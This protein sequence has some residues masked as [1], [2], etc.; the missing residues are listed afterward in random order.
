MSTELAIQDL[1][2]VAKR[3]AASRLFGVDENQAFA[4]MLIAQ[5]RGIPAIEAMQRFHVIQG[6]PSMKSESMLAEWQRAG[7]TCRWLET[8][9]TRAEAEFAH[10][11]FA[12][13]PR[14]ISWTIEDAERAGILAAN[15]SWKKYP[16][17]MLRARV[18]SSAIRMLAPGLT[19]G[20]YTPEEALEMGPPKVVLDATPRQAIQGVTSELEQP[21]EPETASVTLPA[22]QS[23]ATTLDDWLDEFI[24]N[25]N[26]KW[27]AALEGSGEWVSGQG[28][29][30]DDMGSFV[31]MLIDGAT[32][33]GTKL[34]VMFDTE[35]QELNEL[36]SDIARELWRKARPPRAKKPKTATSR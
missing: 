7:G 11:T 19:L 27:L 31:K 22:T 36:A 3:A 21:S 29:L 1:E 33:A 9:D 24:N 14:Q 28:L 15:P 26:A 2:I 5:S 8:S 30:I 10:P 17:A 4:L 32:K 34:D 13:E 20:F 25:V 12:P 18:V 6:R 16:S 35:R 23:Q